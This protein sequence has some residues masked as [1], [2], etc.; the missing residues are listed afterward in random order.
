MI[1]PDDSPE[2][3]NEKLQK[4]NHALMMRVERSTDI[5][6]SAFALFQ[7]ALSLENEVLARTQDL[8]GAL[9]DLGLTNSRLEAAH[10]E[11]VRARRDLANAL[12]AVREGFALFGADDRLV[13]CNRRFRMLLPDTAPRIRTGML[14]AAY[15]QAVSS[16]SHLQRQAGQ[17]VGDWAAMRTGQ[18]GKP[19]ATFTISLTGDRWIQVS[20]RRTPDGGAAI[21]QTDITDMVR[22]QRL[23]R[24]K[25]LDKQAQQVRVILDHMS[26]GV[27]TFDAEGRL[28]ACNLRLSELLALPFDLTQP[29]TG[30]KTIFGYIH[31]NRIFVQAESYRRLNL[32]LTDAQNRQPLQLELRRSD[33]TI[34]DAHFR[35]M[36]DGGFVASFTDVTAER[37]VIDALHKA[38][39]TLEQR[40]NER[41]AALTAANKALVREN[42]DR[43]QIGI[44]LREAKEAAEGA[45]LSKTRFL[46]AASHDL[47]QPMNAAKLF[48]STLRDS[49]LSSDQTEIANRLDRAF[50]SIETLLQALLEISKLDAK[51][52]DFSVT[53]FPVA[54]VLES[55]SDQFAPLAEA[56]G[57][58]F[59]VMPSMLLIRT[60]AG[61]FLRIL[62]NLVSNAIKYTE[63]GAVLVACRRRGK[64]ASIEVWD[65]GPG[66]ESRDQ[67][68]IFEEFQRVTPSQGDPGMGLG[69]S[70]VER[71]CRQLG[72]P[73]GLRSIPGRG[74][75]FSIGIPIE[76]RIAPPIEAVAKEDVGEEESDFDLIAAVVENDPEV[77]FAMTTLLE[78][79][80]VSV[81]PADSSQALLDAVKEIG[82]PPDIVLADYHLG[83]EDTGLHSISLL[84]A[85]AGRQIPAVLITADRSGEL[86]RMARLAQV[87][88]L[89]KPVELQRL[90]SLVSWHRS[91][92]R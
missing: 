76:S 59:R 18:H 58:K 92:R 73:I 31:R 80:G 37:E 44:A 88:I 36:P 13:M 62:Q 84:R 6:G 67:R 26:Q 51:G 9:D 32:W 69:L 38:K 54:P 71:A 47:L 82:V 27:C 72:H 86:R 52:A 4:I 48:I 75:V 2:R 29:G 42:R 1:D 55:L 8:Q 11:A 64:I 14:F 56:K 41:T 63:R 81:V 12:E 33:G 68:R 21:L 83:G 5:S 91:A 65:S 35:S 45:N 49:N 85:A 16:S 61:Y 39:E 70:I 50:T 24:E 90:R 23:E 87:D 25:D 28:N 40:V 53:S 34:L 57:L 20:E 89:S 78:G 77:S 15:V 7:T 66:I 46:A 3:Q 79:W 43:E 22:Q 10:Q 19:Y 30:L 17:S 60:D 74:S